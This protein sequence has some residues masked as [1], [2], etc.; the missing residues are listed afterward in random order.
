MGGFTICPGLSVP[1]AGL[2]SEASWGEEVPPGSTRS[3][4]PVPSWLPLHITGAVVDTATQTGCPDPKY[5]LCPLAMRTA[6][7]A[8]PHGRGRAPAP[9]KDLLASWPLTGSLTF[10]GGELACPP[11]HSGVCPLYGGSI[12]A[13]QGSQPEWPALRP[14]RRSKARC[15][16]PSASPAYDPFSSHSGKAT[17]GGG[18][19]ALRPRLPSKVGSQGLRD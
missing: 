16:L 9:H 11:A 3:G 14:H 18:H 2:A 1:S 8:R 19:P 15:P 4:Q 17:H 13:C 10:P 7:G 5:C 6:M 12:W